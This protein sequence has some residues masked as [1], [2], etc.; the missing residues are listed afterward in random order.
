MNEK[1]TILIAG[2]N[3]FMGVKLLSDVLTKGMDVIALARNN[4]GQTAEQRVFGELEDILSEELIKE[5][6]DKLKVYNY[7][8]N[9]TDLGLTES[10]RDEL[11]ETVDLV[12]NLVGDTNFFPKDI[13]K[14]FA[15]NVNG[16]AN[17][18]NALCRR[19]AV[20]NHVST[21]YVAGKREGI[22]YE[23]ELDVGQEFKNEY[24][25][26]K[27]LG[28][29]KVKEVCAKNNVIFNIFRPSIVI[30]QH[31]VH[32]KMPNLNHFYSFIGLIDILRQDAQ[33]QAHSDKRE[34]LKVPIRF[35]GRKNSTLNFVDLDYA[36]AAMLYI[37]M[38]IKATD[39]T[40]HLVN[41]KPL[42][43]QE[44]LEVIMNLYK[45]EGFEIVEDND[46]FTDLNFY[47]RLIRRGLANYINYFYIN[48]QFDDTNT[49]T[50]LSGTPI[51][52]PDFNIHYLARA[53]GHIA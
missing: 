5:V 15:V 31:F 10:V 9:K 11:N 7:D 47:E 18:I 50:A 38:N 51:R 8:I 13:E 26:S 2:A 53:T 19:Q 45:L 28:E 21:A 27:F 44:F 16:A 24:E 1:K 22:I 48:S 25:K 34:R 39:K 32:G 6:K 4:N 17:I 49:R 29:K 35:P 43:N 52:C 33:T 12:F 42:L 40:Y 20:Y 36:V 3:G 46:V 30:R 41:C 23:S 37:A 14:S